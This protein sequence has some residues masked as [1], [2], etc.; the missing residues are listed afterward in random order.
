[1]TPPDTSRPE[2]GPVF[3]PP[4]R[5]AWH[6]WLATN[7]DSHTV[8]WLRRF[9]QASGVPTISYD[10]MVEECLCFGWIDGVIKRYDDDSNV[11]RI[12]PRRP[13]SSLSELN[14]QRV[15]KLQH[16]G[17]MTAAGLEAL[18]DQVGSPSDP[19][20]IPEW[21]EARL[22]AD[23]ATWEAFMAFPLMYRRLKIAWIV[24]P[25][26]NRQDEREK[27]LAHLIEMTAKGRR[28]GAEPLL[29]ITY[30]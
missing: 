1:M 10:D 13:T 4:D 6:E 19:F 24:G 27:R 9:K 5:A 7:H 30:G 11:Q 21:V 18:G 23:P 29:G 2:L 12:T 17:L 3:Y 20:E 28:Y 8:I 22:R 16:L 26:G 14:R 15:W 25:Q